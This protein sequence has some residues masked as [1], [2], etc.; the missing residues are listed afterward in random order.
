MKIMSF[1]KWKSDYTQNKRIN[2]RTGNNLGNN[3][4]EAPGPQHTLHERKTLIQAIWQRL[5]HTGLLEGTPGPGP[6]G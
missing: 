6:L 2:R 5:G 4:V 3:C 1:R